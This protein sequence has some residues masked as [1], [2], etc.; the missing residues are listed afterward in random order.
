MVE[1]PLVVVL[2]LQQSM[3]AEVL[4]KAITY[5]EACIDMRAQEVEVLKKALARLLGTP[6]PAPALQE[7]PR[8]VGAP[9][10]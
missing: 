6:P 4:R 10:E 3:T 7:R 9:A 2:A 1:D 5:R 8:R